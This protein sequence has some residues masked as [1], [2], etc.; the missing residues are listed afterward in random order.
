MS[1]LLLGDSHSDIF[2]NRSE[3]N[4]F[5]WR[6]WKNSVATVHRFTDT[7]DHD[8]WN[9]VSGW[10]SAS[11]SKTL[12]LSMG[13]I[14]IRAHFWRHIPRGYTS[15]TDIISYVDQVAEKYSQQIKIVAD[16]YN[17]SKVVI[18]SP[19]VAGEKATYNSEYP[20]VGSATT[21]NQLVHI[22]NCCLIT[23]LSLDN[24]FSICSA[25]YDF[26][27]PDTYET[28][29][30]NPSHDGVHWHD[31]F[32]NEFWNKFIQPAINGEQLVIGNNWYTMKDDRFDL[33]TATSNGSLQYDTWAST[34][35]IIDKVVNI[36]GCQYFWVRT[37]NRNLL[38]ATYTELILQKIIP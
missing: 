2:T 26:I 31:S 20:F 19:P 12:I 8:F 34:D 3:V 16:R 36:K 23:K 30:P 27:D 10:L 6:H 29:T 18:W 38:P 25:F 35:N 11:T 17:L 5:D 13:E 4:R 14:D 9:P 24:R 28:I 7:E 1:I 37:E 22:W 32:G 21:R 15:P 33:G